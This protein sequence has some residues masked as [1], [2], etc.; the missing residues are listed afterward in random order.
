M[1]K[2]SDWQQLAAREISLAENCETLSTVLNKVA[3]TLGFDRFLC[4]LSITSSFKSRGLQ[5]FGD[6]LVENMEMPLPSWIFSQGAIIPGCANGDGMVVWEGAGGCEDSKD[7]GRFGV[8]CIVIPRFSVTGVVGLVRSEGRIC[9]DEYID[10]SCGFKTVAIHAIYKAVSLGGSAC[11]YK[12]MLLSKKE[13]QVLRCIADGDTSKQIAKVLHLSVDTVNF[14][15]KRIYKKMGVAN[16][17]QAA[18]YA[19]I[20]GLI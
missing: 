14:H 15:L 20:H 18:A 6:F 4:V 5:V 3:L 1:Y 9:N 17:A 8:A 19:A 10:L 12:E 11:V 13:V 16:K 2:V 7:E